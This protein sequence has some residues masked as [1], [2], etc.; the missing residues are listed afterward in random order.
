[1]EAGAGAK[2]DKHRL[3]ELQRGRVST[4]F[5]WELV[6]AI[7]GE[8][9]ALCRAGGKMTVDHIIPLSRG[10]GNWQ[11]NIRPLCDPCN[12]EK[13]SQ[14]DAEYPGG[15]VVGHTDWSPATD[16]PIVRP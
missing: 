10:G 1:M 5:D 15:R 13:G 4:G 11:F 9:C 16:W 12:T 2:E 14:L 6:L 3:R 8:R 7:Y